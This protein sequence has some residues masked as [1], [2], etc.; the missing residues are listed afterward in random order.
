LERCYSDVTPF[1]VRHADGGQFHL[2]SREGHGIKV[3]DSFRR[4]QQTAS[5]QLPGKKRK[6]VPDDATPD[7]PED[8]PVEISSED[9]ESQE[10]VVKDM[11]AQRG[12]TG[13]Q[14]VLQQASPGV[15]LEQASPHQEDAQAGEDPASPEEA[16]EQESPGVGEPTAP[17]EEDSQEE[18]PLGGQQPTAPPEDTQEASPDVTGHVTTEDAQA[19]QQEQQEPQ[20]SMEV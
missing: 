6:T 10:T 1:Q 14:L 5:R 20:F 7:L 13:T 18:A 9:E 17:P 3:L 11:A 16:S 15:Q 4:K 8:S 12:P 19:T 2:I